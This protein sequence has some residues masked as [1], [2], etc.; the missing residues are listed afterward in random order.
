ML[1]VQFV[2]SLHEESEHVLTQCTMFTH[3]DVV[4]RY[5]H[6][7]LILK[8]AVTYGLY[9]LSMANILLINA[10]YVFVKNILIYLEREFPLFFNPVDS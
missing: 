7:S 10:F 6:Q 4:A 5:P 9:F 3:T 8:V 2:L 1:C